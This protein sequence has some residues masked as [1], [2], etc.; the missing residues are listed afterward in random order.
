M[1]RSPRQ[2]LRAAIWRGSLSALGLG[3]FSLWF[4]GAFPAAILWWRGIPLAPAPGAP[5]WIGAGIAG[6][7]Y[8]A[9]IG[10]A[11]RFVRRGRGTLVPIE[12]PSVLVVAGPYRYVRNPMYLLYVCIAVAEAIAW[13]SAWLLGYAGLLFAIAHAYVVGREEPLLRERFGAAYE[14]YSERV[15]RWWPRRNFPLEVRSS[16]AT[17]RNSR[18]TL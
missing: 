13:R 16:S 3:W 11:L 15:S 14:A 18:G 9:V 5:L 2:G 6:I 10:E 12:P 7:A 17:I 8:S 1:S 4:F